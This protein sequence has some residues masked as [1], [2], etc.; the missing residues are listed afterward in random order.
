MAQAT[1]A[2]DGAK[3][4]A[5]EAAGHAQDRAQQAAGQARDR[6]RSE[7]DRRSTEAGQ[8]VRASADD[9]RAVSDQL[10]EQGR[11]GAAKLAD[12]A[13]ERAQGVGGYLEEQDA[14]T[15]L[16][17]IEDVARRNPWAVMAG[18]MA[19]GFA[20]SRFL[21][22][23]SRARYERRGER[24]LPARAQPAM[25]EPMPPVGTEVG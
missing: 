19:L 22:A 3:E 10:R 6:V 14:D 18:G 17:D 24:S 2:P 16:S 1:R 23:S 5:Q 25:D 4:K 9:L 21:K 15:I 8:R 11:E 13:A 12:Q 7:V 20:A